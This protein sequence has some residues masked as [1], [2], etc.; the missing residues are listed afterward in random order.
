[1]HEI[2]EVSRHKLKDSVIGINVEIANM[3]DGTLFE[4]DLN[5]NQNVHA[6]Q[7]NQRHI[8]HLEIKCPEVIW[9]I[10]N[11]VWDAMRKHLEVDVGH[12][13]EQAKTAPVSEIR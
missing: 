7:N 4:N 1:L 2:T 8:T 6:S 13:S 10:V 9:R 11:E 5:R 12:V 3:V